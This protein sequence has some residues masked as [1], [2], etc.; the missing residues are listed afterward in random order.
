MKSLL[1]AQAEASRLD[2]SVVR[3]RRQARALDNN[4]VNEAPPPIPHLK[5]KYDPDHPDADWGGY[6]QRNYKKKAQYSEH[7]ATR[8]NLM[9]DEK[10]G[11]MPDRSAPV[12]SSSFSGKK[13]F[14]PAQHPAGDPTMPGIQFQSAVYQVGPGA[15]LSC[16]N[17]KTSYEA[18]TT[19]EAP[20]KEMY[21]LG[22]RQNSQ[23]KRHVTP[24][25]EKPVNIHGSR[26]SSPADNNGRSI[27]NG[28]SSREGSP[29]GLSGS[30]SSGSLSGRRI[31]PR[32]SLLAGIGKLVAAEDVADQLT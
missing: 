29:A 15:D 23:H 32:R 17:W 26:Q 3:E 24:L 5:D 9:V 2:D 22:S 1:Q 20:P 25:F 11:I 10:G 7:L 21:A 13:I 31:E 27:Y 12:A 30:D 8:N 19:L 4:A 6:V 28:Y 14:D 18:Q 16:S